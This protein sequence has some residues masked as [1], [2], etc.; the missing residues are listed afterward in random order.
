MSDDERCQQKLTVKQLKWK[1]FF[2]LVHQ[3]IILFLVQTFLAK[4]ISIDSRYACLPMFQFLPMIARTYWIFLSTENKQNKR[5]KKICWKS[6]LKVTWWL[7]E[8]KNG[9]GSSTWSPYSFRFL[10]VFGFFCMRKKFA[11]I[12]AKINQNWLF[13]REHS[14]YES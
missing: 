8:Q 7:N 10:S 2:I 12:P 1:D 4:C 13:L 5:N 11:L 9:F 6:P 14:R 3:T